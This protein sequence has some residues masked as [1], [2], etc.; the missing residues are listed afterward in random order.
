M[1][2]ESLEKNKMIDL[3]GPVANDMWY[4][5]AFLGNPNS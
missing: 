2:T 5:K 4:Q 3:F 1:E